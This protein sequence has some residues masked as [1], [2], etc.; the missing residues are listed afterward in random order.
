MKHARNIAII[1]A[2][3]ALVAYAPSGGNAADTFGW[4]L[5]L[6][7]YAAL[8]WFASTLYRSYRTEIYGLGDQMRGLLY[9][10][11]GVATV[12]VIGTREL[13]ETGPGTLVWFALVGGAS[14]GAFTVFAHWR[15]QNSY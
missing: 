14:F 10:S 8:A 15:E 9:M 13:W 7:M 12:A 3:A 1:V 5:T 2:I 4:I 6:I 11:L